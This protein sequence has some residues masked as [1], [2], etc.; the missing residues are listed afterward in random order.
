LF[1][2]EINTKGYDENILNFEKLEE[3]LL[4]LHFAMS[5]TSKRNFCKILQIINVINGSAAS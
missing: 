4:I 1:T 2:E 5:K 3:K